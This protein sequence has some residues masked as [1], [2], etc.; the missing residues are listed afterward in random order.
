MVSK[1][2]FFWGIM[3]LVIVANINKVGV[4]PMAILVYCFV[5]FMFLFYTNKPDERK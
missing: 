4:S 5:G 3:L 2:Q 1:Q